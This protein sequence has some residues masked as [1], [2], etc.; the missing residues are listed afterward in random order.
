M[1]FNPLHA[2][3]AADSGILDALSGLVSKPMVPKAPAVGHPG[4]DQEKGIRMAGASGAADDLATDP[5]AQRLAAQL[6]DVP[7]PDGF[8]DRMKAG[9]N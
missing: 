3:D 6:N 7:L 1:S 5:A 9:M 2:L 4:C 8:L